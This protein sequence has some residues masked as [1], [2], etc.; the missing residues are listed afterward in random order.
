M[1]L[2]EIEIDFKG[3]K[4]IKTMHSVLKK[5]FGFPKFYGENAHAL[6]DCLSSLRFPEDGMTKI[7]IGEKESLLIKLKNINQDSRKAITLLITVVGDVNQRELEK[8][9]TPSIFL[10]P[11]GDD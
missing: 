5:I 8:G 7:N 10:L 6:I 3:I 9:N 11:I 4:K 1:K 2:K